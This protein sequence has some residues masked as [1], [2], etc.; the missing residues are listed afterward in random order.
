VALAPPKRLVSPGSGCRGG[1]D[2]SSA[3]QRDLSGAL[4]HPAARWR[5]CRVPKPKLALP[6]SRG[7]YEEIGSPAAANR[8]RRWALERSAIWRLHAV[9][10][11][12]KA[13]SAREHRTHHGLSNLNRCRGHHPSGRNANARRSRLTAFA[14][15]ASKHR[16]PRRHGPR[17]ATACRIG[18]LNGRR[19]SL[20]VIYAAKRSLGLTPEH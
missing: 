13:A 20:K 4:H 14:V 17:G 10:V 19:T 1:A 16:A 11:S 9:S 2:S 8:E 5:R 3:L 6:A 15:N 18:G 12:P 7:T